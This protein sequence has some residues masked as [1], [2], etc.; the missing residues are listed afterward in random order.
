[1]PKAQH[2]ILTRVG[3]TAALDELAGAIQ[4]AFFVRAGDLVF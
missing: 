3:E 2:L 4:Q 1:M